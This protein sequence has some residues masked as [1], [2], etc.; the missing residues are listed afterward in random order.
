MALGYWIFKILNLQRYSFSSKNIFY[1]IHKDHVY[2]TYL[3]P[4]KNAVLKKN[5]YF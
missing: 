1:F 3:W 5:T 4:L 2:L